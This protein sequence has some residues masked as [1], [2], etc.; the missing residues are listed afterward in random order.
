MFAAAFCAPGAA[1]G[2][3]G[4]SGS[5]VVL[6]EGNGVKLTL[7]DLE[8]KR[9]TSMF[10][11]R[12]AYYETERKALEDLVDESLLEQQ[13]SKEGVTVPQLLERHVNAVIPKDP[14]D[15]ALRVYYEGVETAEPYEA[16][17]DKI[18]EALKQRRIAK[19]KA[20][21]MQALR[22][23]NPMIIRLAPPRAPIAMKEVA[24]RGAASPRVTLLEFADFECPYC[25]QFQPVLDKLEAEF[26]GKLAFAYKDF[27]LPMHRDA[28]KAAE[29]SHC[30]GAQGK[31]WEFHDMMFAKKQLDPPALKNYATSLKLDTTAFTACL[32]SGQMAG[33]VKEH[34]AEAQALGL[35]GTP[36]FFVNGRAISGNATY[37]KLRAII[38]EELSAVDAQAESATTRNQQQD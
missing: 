32:D 36:S 30:A 22:S 31:Y 4:P 18:V 5:A 34:A 7:A 33:V 17:R 15:E 2:A 14:S 29:A 21:Y 10:Q 8:Q 37:E 16:V 1:P 13:A 25:Q 24:V 23:Q 27:P 11:A 9:A 3:D 6:V 19:A 35:Q 28:E 38:G 12:T 20:A 26:K